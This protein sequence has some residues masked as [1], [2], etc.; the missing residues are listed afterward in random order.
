MLHMAYLREQVFDLTPAPPGQQA[1]I[2]SDVFSAKPILS[3]NGRFTSPL[4]GASLQP[5]LQNVCIHQANM[6]VHITRA[7]GKGLEISDKYVFAAILESVSHHNIKYFDCTVAYFKELCFTM[8]RSV[9]MRS[10]LLC[11]TSVVKSRFQSVAPCARL[12]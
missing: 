3:A 8:F 4:D 12:I 7:D 6:L 5:T 9:M 1:V 2:V 10:L 11:R